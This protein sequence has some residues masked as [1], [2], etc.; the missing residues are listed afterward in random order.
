[1]CADFLPA[2]LGTRRSDQ[3]GA[4]SLDVTITRLHMD[5]RAPLPSG[6]VRGYVEY[7]LNAGNDGSPDFKLRHAYGTWK[8]EYG[9]LTAGHTW[10]TAMDLKI[11]PEGLTEP[12]VS[13][14]IFQRQALLRWSQ[15]LGKGYTIHAA[16]EDP[17]SSDVF[18]TSSVNNQTSIP[19]GVLGLEY[20]RN[21]LWHL[22]LNGLARNLKVDLPGGGNDSA[23]GWG[24]ALT[25]HINCFRKDKLCFSGIYGEGLGRYLLGIESTAGSLID[26]EKNE[27]SLRKNWGIMATYEHHWT[28]SLRSTAMGGYAHS[29]T[30]SWQT[31]DTFESSTYASVNLMWSVYRYIT[32]GVE[33]AYGKRDNKDHSDIDNHRVAVGMQFY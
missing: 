26:P 9:T 28:D 7:D 20:D 8:N 14:V 4:T 5:G 30:M 1:M 12:T 27:I 24:L 19:D 31:G 6:Q 10:S 23:T 33:Y 21:G 2:T 17:S 18:S 13:G 22:R 16:I 3:E 25:G 29:G 11:L 32:L 15:P